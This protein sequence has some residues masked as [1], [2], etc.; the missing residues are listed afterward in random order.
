MDAVVGKTGHVT[1]LYGSGPQRGKYVISP[2]GELDG[3]NAWETADADGNLFV[4][5]AVRKA[6]PRSK[7]SVTSNN[8]AA[9]TPKRS[10]QRQSAA[11]TYFAPW[12]WCIRSPRYWM[13]STSATRI[14]AALDRLVAWTVLGAVVALAVCGGIAMWTGRQLNTAIQGLIGEAARLTTAAVD[15]KL[16]SAATPHPSARSFGRL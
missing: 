9:A 5:G 7:A 15:G 10:T 2:K 12:D 13:T 3:R 4:Q 16:Q 11:V 14:N 6:R 8:T 1:V